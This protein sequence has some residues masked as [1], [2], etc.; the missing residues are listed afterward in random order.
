MSTTLEAAR[1]EAL[2]VSTLQPSDRPAPDAVRDAVGAVLR[3]FGMRACVCQVAKEFGEH[4]E[5][6]AARM[7]WALSAIRSTFPV[8]ASSRPPRAAAASAGE[9]MSVRDSACT[10]SARAAA[11]PAA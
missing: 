6:A 7:R 9:V 1:A 2:F 3:R 11:R 10:T 4:P 8:V 5:A